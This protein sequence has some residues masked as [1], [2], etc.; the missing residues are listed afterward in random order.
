MTKPLSRRFKVSARDAQRPRLETAR[1]FGRSLAE[2]NEDDAREFEEDREEDDASAESPLEAVTRRLKRASPRFASQDDWREQPLEG[3]RDRGPGREPPQLARA[4][5][6]PIVDVDEIAETAAAMVAHRVAESERHTAKALNSLAQM[7]ESGRRREDE[8]ERLEETVAAIARRAEANERK[9]ARALE[10]IAEIIENGGRGVDDEEIGA[11][12]ET[13]GR[14]ESRRARPRDA[15]EPRPIRSALARNESRADRP[16]RDDRANGF[17]QA[18]SGLDQRLA[19]ISARLEEDARTRSS[20]SSPVGA[21]APHP[22]RALADAIADITRRQQTLDEESRGPRH[23]FASRDDDARRLRLRQSDDRRASSANSHSFEARAARES[24]ERE[25]HAAAVAGHLDSLRRRIEELAS[26]GQPELTRR[27]DDLRGALETQARQLES[28]RSDLAHRPDQQL[29][30]LRQIESLRR[31]TDELARAQHDALSRRIEDLRASHDELARHIESRHGDALQRP[32]QHFLLM[33]EIEA[34]H[35]RVAEA[36]DAESPRVAERFG[37]LSDA[38]VTLSQQLAELR[39]EASQNARQQSLM[40]RQ[41]DG[42]RHE[43]LDLSRLMNDIAPR[44]SVAAVEEALRD[45]VARID[46]QRGRGVAEHALAPAERVAYEL[47]TALK[48]LD[49]APMLRHLDADVAAILRRLDEVKTEGGADAAAL[50]ELARQTAEIKDGLRHLASRP[51]PVEKLETRLVDLTQRVEKLSLSAASA[52]ASADIG[53]VV[54]SIRSIVATETSNGFDAFNQRLERLTEKLDGA[55]SLSGAQRF[56][57]LSARIDEMHRSLAQRIDQGVGAHRPTTT[58]GLE[59]TLAKLAR[60]IDGALDTKTSHPAF[61]ELG[62]KIDRLEGRIGEPGAA[63]GFA[64]IERLLAQPV[65]EDRFARIARRLED[66]AQTLQ[67][68]AELGAPTRSGAD[69]RRFEDLTHRLGERIDAALAPGAAR[70]AFEPVARQVQG[71]SEKLD[72]LAATANRAELDSLNHQVGHMGHL[73]GMLMERLEQGGARAELDSLVHQVGHQ[74]HQLGLLLQKLD[75]SVA[76]GNKGGVD[77]LTHQIGHL[78]HL[79]GMVLGKLESGLAGA[80]QPALEQ[81]G[82]QVAQLAARLE[83]LGPWSERVENLLSQPSD[84]RRFTDIAQR[85]EETGRSLSERLNRHGV[86]A[87]L[88]AVEDIVRRLGERIDQALAP[89]ARS[90]ELAQVEQQIAALSAKIDQIAPLARR[91][92][93]LAARTAPQAQIEQLGDRINFMQDALAARI[94]EGGRAQA[95]ELVEG[96]A[97]RIDG[98]LAPGANAQAFAALEEQ[99][100]ALSARLDQ[101]AGAGPASAGVEGRIGELLQRFDQARDDMAG[102]AEAALREATLEVV[103]EANAAA[104]KLN[105]AVQQ[106]L[107]ELRRTQDA[108]GA[109]THETLSVV[110]ETLERVVD[111]LAA[112]EEELTELRIEPPAP[113]RAPEPVVETHRAVPPARGPR[114]QEAPPQPKPRAEPD[115]PAAPRAGRGRKVEDFDLD[116][117]DA[118]RSTVSAAARAEAAPTDFIAAARRAAQKAAAEADAAQA[119]LEQRRNAARAAALAAANKSGGA[120]AESGG[121][122]SK[123]PML[124]ALATLLLVGAGGFYGASRFGLLP[125]G[126]TAPTQNDVAALNQKKPSAHADVDQPAKPAAPQ[127]AAPLPAPAQPAAPQTVGP[128]G[129]MAPAA[130]V[131]LG[132]LPTDNTP[133]GTINKPAGATAEESSAILQAATRG[134]AAA[135]YEYA[136]RLAEGRGVPRDAKAAAL[137]FEKAAGQG[138]APAQYRLGSIYEKGVGV[139]RDYGKARSW[140]QQAADAG[141]ARAMH[142]LAV[143]FAEGNDGKADYGTASDWFRKAAELGVRDSQFNLAILYARGLGVGQSLVQSYMWFAVAAAQGDQDATRKRDDVGARLD[144]KELA[145][146]KELVENFK[147]RPLKREANEPPAPK[148]GWEALKAQ[149]FKPDTKPFFAPSAKPKA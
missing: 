126:E 127:T 106:E 40:L 51:F 55:L 61:E 117:L 79:V 41:M 139:D 118:E 31:D 43:V 77:E 91:V 136:A 24:E 67:S 42:L 28:L 35:R 119:D 26:V 53:D 132:A 64:R 21:R 104:G 70:Q 144:S 130:K 50:A 52:S 13:F 38:V 57:E 122:S 108:S 121:G 135:Q 10:S 4:P 2:E 66:A 105:P 11:S 68:K 146:A 18:L 120:A 109:R 81:L 54:R 62:R 47:R 17:A 90:Q 74:G 3:A 15:D 16:S 123:L 137:W 44:A 78:G 37:E 87:D 71:L 84:L 83:Q 1:R 39:G 59:S 124:L 19:E 125:G 60:K 94:A 100:K 33:R 58:A 8:Q 46:A 27:I 20:A 115:F 36:A 7:I 107:E 96:L 76:S 93:E 128:S 95:A 49:P 147:P 23:S 101:S 85:L 88:G 98:A 86:G 29:A 80:N 92:E 134:D 113:A 30:V 129:A 143:L 133:I 112:F 148:G 22:K 97:R 56:D 102:A 140:Y 45:L 65:N 145:K 99:I 142:N 75:E 72:A 63:E 149:T 82:R 116:E 69:L 32:E 73:V 110:H 138:L 89:G 14:T 6:E 141:N 25:A 114:A 48:E 5:D 9:T 111:R 103:R 34:L 131:G 12:S